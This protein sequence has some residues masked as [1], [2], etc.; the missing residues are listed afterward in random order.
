LGFK[1]ENNPI[2]NGMKLVWGGYIES[3][4][5]SMEQMRRGGNSSSETMKEETKRKVK[6]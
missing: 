5:E 4:Q 6:R 1:G 2:L 3:S